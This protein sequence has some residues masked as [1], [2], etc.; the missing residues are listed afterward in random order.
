MLRM[1]VLMT[2]RSVAQLPLPSLITRALSWLRAVTMNTARRRSTLVTVLTLVS[3]LTLTLPRSHAHPIVVSAA[4]LTLRNIAEHAR[5]ALLTVTG[6]ALGAV[7]M[8]TSWQH[9]AVPAAWSLISQVT[10]AL[11]RL[12][13]V[14]VLR[15]TVVAT[16]RHLT[17]VTNPALVTLDLTIDAGVPLLVLGSTRLLLP[18]SA[19]S[20][21]RTAMTL[22]YQ[23][24]Y[25]SKTWEK[26]GMSHD[27]Y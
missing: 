20:C 9:Y 19:L 24:E 7:T 1:T 15:I 23:D 10:L 22:F 25:K 13:T 27:H 12:D 6:E 8:L 3:W 16:S 14:A 2:D 26:S 11:A 17:Q 5:P 4:S 18:T 21:M